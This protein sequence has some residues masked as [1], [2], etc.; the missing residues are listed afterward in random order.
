MKKKIGYNQ[1]LFRRTQSRDSHSYRAIPVLDGLSEH[2]LRMAHEARE[3]T[4]EAWGISVRGGSGIRIG[5]DT[6]NGRLGLT[7]WRRTH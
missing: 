2:L 3:G 4:G 5:A 6:R 7:K 1:F